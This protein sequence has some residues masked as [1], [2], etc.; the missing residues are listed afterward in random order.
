MK[1]RGVC[2]GDT[3]PIVSSGVEVAAYR[4]F[5]T[6]VSRVEQ[7][8][9]KFRRITLSGKS[10][11]WF[12]PWGLDQR[13]KIVLPRPGLIHEASPWAGPFDGEV[14][15]LAPNQWRQLVLSL[16]A[17]TRHPLRTYTPRHV[18]PDAQ[19]VDIDFFI[20]DPSGPASQW[21]LKARPGDRLV[22]SG[23]D[24]R[25]QDR[26]LGIQWCPPVSPVM[27]LL[28]GDEAAL[29]A[30]S[31]IVASLTSRVV[32]AVFLE[33]DSL[34]SCPPMKAVPRGVRVS[35]VTRLKHCPGQALHA[36]LNKWAEGEAKSAEAAGER[37]AAWIATESTVVAHI[38]AELISA[39][40]NPAV[41]IGQGYW[42]AG[43]RHK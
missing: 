38:K 14:D 6:T 40:I 20:H 11:K 8:S 15:G 31:A 10:L 22:I 7:A 12:A 21:A 23:P 32:G 36:A 19:E 35:V 29:P 1:H 17:E 16:P 42:R 33:A 43:H 26:E 13:I 28:A 9:S 4:L 3:L 18:R 34:T 25:S 27:V 30:M 24:V 37:F 5:D 39:G 41:V 2:R